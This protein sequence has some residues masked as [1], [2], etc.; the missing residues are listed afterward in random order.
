MTLPS[1]AA[2]RAFEAVGRLHGFRRA[3]AALGISHAIVS[4]HVGGIERQ[5]ETTL[6]D[7]RTGAL[8]QAGTVYHA[9]ISAAI[10]EMEAA[11]RAAQ[12]S[13]DRALVIWSSAGFAL[14]WLT[15]RLPRFAGRSRALV[16]DLRS[17]EQEPLLETGEAD[18]DIR[19]IADRCPA[20]SRPG[21][22]TIGLARPEVYP[23]AAPELLR[24]LPSPIVM[25]AHLESCPLIEEV[26]R[27]EWIAW[28]QACRI[29]AAGLPPPV[30]RY[31]QA[32]LAIAAARTGQGIALANDFLVADDLATGRLVRVLP[33]KAG[34]ASGVAIGAY[35]LRV[36]AVRRD[37]PRVRRFASWLRSEVAGG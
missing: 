29:E 15:G 17:T 19:Y 4:R 20:A 12:G 37:D 3:A 26:D 1:F 28:L 11:G 36:L 23:V 33:D 34:S 9:R 21:V 31:G 24:K 18:G 35:V 6:I 8:T 22:L 2:L 25:P 32:H 7:R 10:S 30:A 27:G 5:L 14:Q 13:R 16:V